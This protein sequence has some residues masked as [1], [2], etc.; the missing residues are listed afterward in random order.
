MIKAAGQFAYHILKGHVIQV[1]PLMLNYPQDDF[2]G[3]LSSRLLIRWCYTL[4]QLN[5]RYRRYFGQEMMSV[6]V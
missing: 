2:G 4:L 1:A 3:I 5:Y 6:G